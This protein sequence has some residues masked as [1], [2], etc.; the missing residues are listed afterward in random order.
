MEW[1]IDRLLVC[2]SKISKPCPRLSLIHSHF[3]AVS[4]SQKMDGLPIP[5]VR[6]SYYVRIWNSSYRRT[7]T[8][9]AAASCWEE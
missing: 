2:C 8:P 9:R 7:D 6:S 5:V 1:F 4:G 3:T